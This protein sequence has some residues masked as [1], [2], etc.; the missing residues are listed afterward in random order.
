[1]SQGNSGIAT[2]GH[3]QAC[4]WIKFAG[5]IHT[6]SQRTVIRVYVANRL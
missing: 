2:S 3:T 5:K 1:M 4:A 6:E